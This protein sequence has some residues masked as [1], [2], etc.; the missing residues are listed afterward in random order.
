MSWNI[1]HT[2]QHQSHMILSGF[3]ADLY[4][5]KPT[6]GSLNY[7]TAH[8]EETSRTASCNSVTPAAAP[9]GSEKGL[10]FSRTTLRTLHV[11]RTCWA[12]TWRPSRG[13]CHCRPRLNPTSTIL[14]ERPTVRTAR[15][16]I[17]RVLCIRISVAVFTGVHHWLLPLNSVIVSH[18]I[19]V[20]SPSLFHLK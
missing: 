14:L 15:Q 20:T 12:K 4:C 13:K 1:G 8:M 5:Y 10:Y 18:F 6:P 17:T 11:P 9:D 19:S 3:K 2:V 7:S 16:Q